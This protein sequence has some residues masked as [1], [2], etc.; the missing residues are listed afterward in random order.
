MRPLPK[1]GDRLCVVRMDGCMA[2]VRGPE[3]WG[4]IV[5][6]ADV[7]VRRNGCPEPWAAVRFDDGAVSAE[8]VGDAV[9]KGDHFERQT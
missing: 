4:T 6:Q 7:T 2:H 3:R 9:D 8:H 1:A 5:A